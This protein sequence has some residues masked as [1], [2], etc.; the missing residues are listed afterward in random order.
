MVYQDYVGVHQERM[1]QLAF[2]L[3]SDFEKLH[4]DTQALLFLCRWH[5]APEGISLLGDIPTP[6]KESFDD[7]S[8]K[9]HVLY[10]LSNIKLLAEKILC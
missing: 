4:I 5:D 10:E 9:I 1:Y 7:I 2:L 6:S 3:S 8:K